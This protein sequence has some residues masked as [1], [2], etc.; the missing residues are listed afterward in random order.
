MWVV[1]WHVPYEELLFKLSRIKL[2]FRFLGL[3][4]IY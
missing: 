2:K 3:E 1:G 4:T